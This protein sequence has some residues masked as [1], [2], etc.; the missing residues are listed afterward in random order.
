M[1][2]LVHEVEKTDLESLGDMRLTLAA[3]RN[4][5]IG[6]DLI[7]RIREDTQQAKLAS[8]NQLVTM[9]PA[10]S[11]QISEAAET[12]AKTFAEQ[13]T[14]LKKIQALGGPVSYNH[15]TIDSKIDDLNPIISS[16]R[17]DER[18]V[19]SSAIMQAVSTDGLQRLVRAEL[20]RT[21]LPTVE[22]YLDSYN[23]SH[24]IQLEEIRKS[25]D[26]IV[27]DLGDFM[28]TLLYQLIMRTLRSP[29]QTVKISLMRAMNIFI[30]SPRSRE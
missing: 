11:K 5:I 13:A 22:Q 12:E 15:T 25:L 24:N 3:L 18:R 23:F 8:T 20:R 17:V 16:K 2:V 1:N 29:Q 27:L 26:R 9:E 14:N 7:T 21:A 28:M 6:F 4:G 19:T 30:A 10:L